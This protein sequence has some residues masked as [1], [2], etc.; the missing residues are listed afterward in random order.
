MLLLQKVYGAI[1]ET[2]HEAH[3]LAAVFFN[4]HRFL[5]IN[6]M[7]RMDLMRVTPAP[8]LRYAC[9]CPLVLLYL[10]NSDVDFWASHRYR[11]GC[12]E[13]LRWCVVSAPTLNGEH[14]RLSLE[15]TGRS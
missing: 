13:C 5:F 9:I 8:W 14:H 12:G 15:E 1:L 6:K 2:D 10:R 4:I 3:V 7:K 11:T